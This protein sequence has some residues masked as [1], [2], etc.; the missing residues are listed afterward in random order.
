MD[1][2]SNSI[3]R[4][5]DGTE[6][7]CGIGVTILRYLVSTRG[8]EQGLIENSLRMFHQVVVALHTTGVTPAPFCDAV[9][10]LMAGLM[11]SS[12]ASSR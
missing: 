4:A 5:N 12:K 11:T 3:N 8:T 2:G 10:K 9:F 7:G 6:S 1:C